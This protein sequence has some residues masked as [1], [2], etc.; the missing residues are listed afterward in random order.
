MS[1]CRAST[2]YPSLVADIGQLLLCFFNSG[3]VLSA[4]RLFC[5]SVDGARRLTLEAGSFFLLRSMRA[6]M[7]L[8]SPNFFIVIIF[9]LVASASALANE[10]DDFDSWNRIRLLNAT[11]RDVV[12][13]GQATLSADDLESITSAL[14]RRSVSCQISR[15]KKKRQ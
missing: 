1:R 11:V 8:V 9:L 7:K 5:G 3:I 14:S 12:E 13:P 6:L 2:A 10:P 15:L 4:C